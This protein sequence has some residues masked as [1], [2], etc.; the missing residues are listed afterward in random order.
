MLYMSQKETKD[1]KQKDVIEDYLK[2]P[3]FVLT[4][5]FQIF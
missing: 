2:L 3:C 5:I 1:C 4:Y